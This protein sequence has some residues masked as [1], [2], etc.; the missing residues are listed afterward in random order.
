[1]NAATAS[2]VDPTPEG[3]TPTVVVGLGRTGLSLARFLRRQGERF[4][5]TDSRMEPPG[6]SSLLAEMP[7]V[8]LS[9]GSY[10][11]ALLARAQRILV[12]PGVP[13]SEPPLEAARRRGAEVIGDI[14]IFARHVNAPVVAVTGANGKS[15]V[16]ALAGEMAR[17]AGRNVQLGGN[18][19]TPALDLL[20]DFSANLY[21]LELSSFQLETVSS[22][23]ALAAVVLNVTPDHMDRYTNLAEYAAAKR[24]IYR[25]SGTMVLNADDSRVA[26]MREPD[27]AIYWFTLAAPRSEREFGVRR[28]DGGR[29]LARGEEMLLP[30][31]DL[32]IKGA[33]NVANA[34]AALALGT[35]MEL[36][37]AAMTATLRDFGGLPH[38]CQWVARIESVDWFNDSKGTN[39]GAT[40]AAILGLAEGRRVVLI[41]G[42]D[43]KG[44]DFAELAEAAAGRL[45]AAVVMGRDGPAIERALSPRVPVLRAG[46]MDDAVAQAAGLAARGDAVLLS[47]ACASFDMFRDYAHRGEVFTRAVQTR[48]EP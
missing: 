8:P 23:N 43:G 39:V 15:T 26:A 13:L 30:V 42:G 6:K 16:T 47:P 1:M 28:N 14:E 18:L 35:A 32:R 44:Q 20:A 17:R 34:L 41:A 36:Q 5:V 19:G 24:R 37:A 33:H 3:G 38:R 12:S 10:D 29:W 25:G 21:V 9:L 11:A 4:A 22:L 2:R 31:E 27:R 7:E 48:A 40:V 45:R 46:N